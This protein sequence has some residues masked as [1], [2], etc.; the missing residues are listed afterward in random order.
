VDLVDELVELVA[1]G[2]AQRRFVGVEQDVGVEAR[3]LASK[4][5]F[6]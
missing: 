4:L 2:R 3:M 6:S 5:T 1:A